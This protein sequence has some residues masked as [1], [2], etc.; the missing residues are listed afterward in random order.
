MPSQNVVFGRHR[1]YFALVRGNV[2][3]NFAQFLLF[4]FVLFKDSAAVG[5][6]KRSGP[7]TG[8][9]AALKKHLRGPHYF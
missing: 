3:P 2:K 4:L 5:K 1:H 6:S 8:A 9:D 7:D